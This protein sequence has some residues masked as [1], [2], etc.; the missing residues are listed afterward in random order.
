MKRNRAKRKIK[1]EEK[2]IDY[3]LLNFQNNKIS[4]LTVKNKRNISL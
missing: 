2:K 3:K 1:K 4:I